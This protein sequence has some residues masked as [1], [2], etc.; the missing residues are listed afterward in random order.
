MKEKGKINYTITKDDSTAKNY[1][2]KQIYKSE[3]WKLI[4]GNLIL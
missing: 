4:K 2:R 1:I 3:N